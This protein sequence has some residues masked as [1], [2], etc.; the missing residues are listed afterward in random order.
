[1]ADAV[2]DDRSVERISPFR[3]V[4]DDEFRAPDTHGSHQTGRRKQIIVIV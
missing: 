2:H 1:M 3:S 4:A